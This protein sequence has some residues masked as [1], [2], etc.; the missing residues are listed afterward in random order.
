M[1]CP[2]DLDATLARHVA[3]EHDDVGVGL[4]DQAKRLRSVGGRTDEREILLRRERFAK[5]CANARVVVGD[6]HAA[7]DPGARH[8]R[9]DWAYS[10]LTLDGLSHVLWAGKPKLDEKLAERDS[11][12]APAVLLGE[13]LLELGWANDAGLDQMNADARIAFGSVQEQLKKI[14]EVRRTEW[15]HDES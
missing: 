15:L 6:H 7:N 5:A 14:R 10:S 4:L 11:F 1:Q 2:Q 8:R 3:V 12:P 9:G 13:R